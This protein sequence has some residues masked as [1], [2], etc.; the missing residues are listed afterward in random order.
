MK[1]TLFLKL[2]TKIIIFFRLENDKRIHRLYFLKTLVKP[3]QLEPPFDFSLES[4]V[5][6]N[7]LRNKQPPLIIS[8]FLPSLLALF[9]LIKHASWG[10][11][12]YF[13]LL[14]YY[15]LLA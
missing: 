8:D 1:Q 4:P 9:Y 15:L 5:T 6:L 3:D 7:D 2:I 10:T 14:A 13:T 11:L 12:F